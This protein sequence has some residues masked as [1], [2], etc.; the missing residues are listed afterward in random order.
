MPQ[1]IATDLYFWYGGLV[2]ALFIVL[3]LKTW[4]G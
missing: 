4:Y 2:I 3:A 1:L